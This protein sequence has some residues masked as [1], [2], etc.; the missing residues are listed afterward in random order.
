MY[1]YIYIHIHTHTHTHLGNGISAEG[2]IFISHMMQAIGRQCRLA[3]RFM[4]HSFG[5]G[6]PVR[7]GKKVS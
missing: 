5:V 6:Q 7:S 3:E 2:C 1:I 4:N